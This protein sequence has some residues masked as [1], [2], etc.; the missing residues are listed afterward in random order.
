MRQRDLTREGAQTTK[1]TSNELM[2]YHKL[3]KEA[4]RG[5]NGEKI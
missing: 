5:R 3:N 2:L 1:T 4:E